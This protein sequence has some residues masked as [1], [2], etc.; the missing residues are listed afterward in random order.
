MLAT[1]AAAQTPAQKAQL[2][3]VMYSAFTCSTYAS[4]SGN[5]KEQERLFQLGLKAGRDFLKAFESREIPT[6]AMQT[7]VPIGVSL[8]LAG[9]THDFII[10]RI[11]EAVQTTAYKEVAKDA[12][13]RDDGD[14]SKMRA[15]NAFTAANCSLIK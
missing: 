10:G 6:D 9:P 8:Y 4:M 1:P 11:F 7:E 5:N 12:L 3:R 15:R 13:P 14:L 2:A